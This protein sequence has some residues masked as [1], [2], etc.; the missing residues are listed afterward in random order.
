MKA[1]E[2]LGGFEYEGL[3]RVSGKQTE[4]EDLHNM[5]ASSTTDDND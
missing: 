2:E 3:F 1:I 4:E 5:C